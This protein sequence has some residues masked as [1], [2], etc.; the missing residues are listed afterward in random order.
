MG[1]HKLELATWESLQLLVYN[2]GHFYK[3]LLK[4]TK[5]IEE[6]LNKVSEMLSE[7][8][9]DFE[10]FWNVKKAKYITNRETWFE[11]NCALFTS[12]FWLSITS[13]FHIKISPRC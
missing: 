7:G 8:P 4:V 9:I 11:S 3:C 10:T 2:F 5:I 12:W 6:K 13:E 1:A